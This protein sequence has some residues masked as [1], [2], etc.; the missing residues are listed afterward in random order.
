M[1]RALTGR[2]AMTSAS[3]LDSRAKSSVL[4]DQPAS[5]SFGNCRLDERSARLTRDGIDVAIEKLPFAMLVYFLRHPEVVH[6]KAELMEALWPKR[7]VVESA[8]SVCVNKLRQAIGDHDGRVLVTVHRVGYRFVEH[9]E[10]ESLPVVTVEW[11]PTPGA[12][13]P[14]R[15]SWQLVRHVGTSTERGMWIAKHEKTR[16]LRAFKFALPAERVSVLKNELTIQRLLNRALPGSASFTRVH[17]WRL[18]EQPYWLEFDALDGE[19]LRSLMR[20]WRLRPESAPPVHSRIAWIADLAEALAEAHSLG[21]LHRDLSP[22]NVWIA[23]DSQGHRQVLLT[24]FGSGILSDNAKL[25]DLGITLAGESSAD[26]ATPLYIAPEIL[27]GASPTIRSDVYALGVIL[28]QTLIGDEHATLDP[29]WESKIGDDL[30]CE[31]IWVCCHQDPPKRLGDAAELAS[32]LRRLAERHQQRELED[33]GAK[34]M[35][36]LRVAEAKAQERLSAIRQRR[37]WLFL[38]LAVLSVGLVSSIWLAR[39]AQ[40]QRRLAEQQQA[41]ALHHKD[42]S[43]A[44]AN[45][46]VHITSGVANPFA[47]GQRDTTVREMLNIA[48]QSVSEN[49]N[50]VPEA[51]LI[52]RAELANAFSSLNEFQK[53]H[54]QAELGLALALRTNSPIRWDFETRLADIDRLQWRVSNASRRIA[55][56]LKQPGLPT[57]TEEYLRAM[58]AD[59][60]LD[61]G[62]YEDALAEIDRVLELLGKRQESDSSLRN[63]MQLYRGRAFLELGKV[64]LARSEFLAIQTRSA[65]ATHESKRDPSRAGRRG[66][67]LV[68][69]RTG[70]FDQAIQDQTQLVS[71]LK[72]GFGEGSGMHIGMVLMLARSLL[73]A[74]RCEDSLRQIE[75]IES[76]RQ[77]LEPRAGY[78]TLRIQ[79]ELLRGDHRMAEQVLKTAMS[80]I[81]AMYDRDAVPVVRVKA[82]EID[83]LV[84]A[85]EADSAKSQLQQLI[86]SLAQLRLEN[87]PESDRLLVRYSDLV[88]PDQVAKARERLVARFGESAP[89]LHPPRCSPASGGSFRSDSPGTR[90]R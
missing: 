50:H 25:R 41:Q 48:A 37:R 70:Q 69:W 7:V 84:K 14:G 40:V 6:T 53:A 15:E 16:E 43:D 68:H 28:L 26:S 85:G 38:L 5:W 90:S 78:W 76:Y 42:V 32:R 9:P 55:A 89:D 47:V 17:E 87:L 88:A 83:R 80:T 33:Q 63:G 3:A 39:E 73:D 46:F 19:D 74:G 52:V 11:T 82:L 12:S 66:M 64:E 67:A 4:V 86:E 65:A 62:R 8:L 22:S 81:G 36:R 21:V 30:L 54:E 51:E 77:L 34:E 2:T 61:I 75:S 49:V 57:H 79:H 24:D 45:F 18:D 44:V 72:E 29:G 10:R 1:V 59:I 31:D 56:T 71:E 27:Q 35:E 60:L 13:V 58:Q 20:A 23:A